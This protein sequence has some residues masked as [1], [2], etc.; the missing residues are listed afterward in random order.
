MR[1]EGLTTADW[2]VVME[3]VNLHKLD[4]LRPL[5]RKCSFKKPEWLEGIV[6]YFQWYNADVTGEAECPLYLAAFIKFV[7]SAVIPLIHR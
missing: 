7:C 4:V 6:V 5:K 3:Y 2:A 1:S